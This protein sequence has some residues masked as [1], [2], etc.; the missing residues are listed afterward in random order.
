MKDLELS[1]IGWAVNSLENAIPAFRSL[2]YTVKGDVCID[3]A[4]KVKLVL[5]EDSCSN[6]IEL[7][8]P[9]AEDSPVSDIL[10][11]AGP[12]PYHI[13][14][15]INNENWQKYRDSLKKSGFIVLHKPQMAPLFGNDEVVFLYSKD[16]GLIEIVLQNDFK[17]EE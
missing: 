11:K 12:T 17:G 16:I 1:H 7:V 6:V 8:A 9:A 15:A 2:G 10:K 5:L 3:D 13:C 14:F 4:R